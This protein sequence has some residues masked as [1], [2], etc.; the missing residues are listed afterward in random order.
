MAAKALNCPGY[1]VYGASHTPNTEFL[2]KK[3]VCKA[4]FDRSENLFFLEKSYRV[5]SD[6]PGG[7]I[8]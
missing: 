2:L 6:L 7:H 3:A 8:S 5:W 4:S 1:T